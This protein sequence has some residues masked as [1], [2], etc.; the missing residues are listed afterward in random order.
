MSL[1]FFAFLS[2]ATLVS[3]TLALPYHKANFA[4]TLG[5]SGYFEGKP[6]YKYFNFYEKLP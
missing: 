1:K 4:S 2:L 5:E 6:L 3:F